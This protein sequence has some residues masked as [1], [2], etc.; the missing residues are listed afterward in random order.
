MIASIRYSSRSLLAAVA[1]LGPLSA[2]GQVTNLFD[3]SGSTPKFYARTSTNSYNP[4][5]T[6]IWI[7]V[8]GWG[9]ENGDLS[10]KG[11]ISIPESGGKKTVISATADGG[12]TIREPGGGNLTRVTPMSGGGLVIRDSGSPVYAIPE[13]NGSIRITGPGRNTLNAVASRDGKTITIWTRSGRCYTIPMP[14]Q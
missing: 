4:E 1:L 14:A 6:G 8:S 7:N 12:L 9:S 3:R 11:V 5:T 2:S 13:G 10:S